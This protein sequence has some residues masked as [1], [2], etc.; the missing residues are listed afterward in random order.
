MPES[1]SETPFI[2]RCQGDELFGILAT[3]PEPS[4]VGVLVIVGG[5]QYRA[6]SHRQFVHLSRGLA[7]RGIACMRFDYRGMGDSSGAMR[8]YENIDADI[9]AAID[10]FFR[11]CRHVR[12]IALWGLCGAASAACFYAA[13]D[14][15]V[16]SVILLNP[17][18]RT[19]VGLARTH[20]RYYYAR[21]LIS[22]A[23]WKR[24]FR[25]ELMVAQSIVSLAT[26][27][28]LAIRG[29]RPSDQAAG[30]PDSASLP[31]RMAEAL[32]K[33]DGRKLVVLSEKDYTANE[34]MIAR[35][36]SA[37]WDRAL[38]G[39][40]TEI[41]ANADHT[42]SDATEKKRIVEITFDFVCDP[43]GRTS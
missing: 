43:D 21:R 40:R 1:F 2:F 32:V 13:S 39:S 24:V 10:A 14:P 30:A 4:K 33:F 27:I 22:R 11:N 9:R 31:T 35:S 28:R 19:E 18:V 23:F 34:F 42:F 36:G 16:S 12:E 17:W 26:S 7:S 6:G 38:R 37:L 5:P 25:G 15:R 41:L 29:G 20:L 8:S 3:P